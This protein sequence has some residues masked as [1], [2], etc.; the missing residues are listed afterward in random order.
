MTSRIG[1]WTGYVDVEVQAPRTL[2]RDA[3][4]QQALAALEP[5]RHRLKPKRVRV[6]NLFGGQFG[7]RFYL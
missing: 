5:S 4:I 7:V 3:V 1:R 6:T 2:D